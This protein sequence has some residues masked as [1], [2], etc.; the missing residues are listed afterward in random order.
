MLCKWDYMQSRQT[1]TTTLNILSPDEITI[2][3]DFG[4]NAYDIESDIDFSMHAR[5][6]SNPSIVSVYDTVSGEEY[7][8]TLNDPNTFVDRDETTVTY[9]RTTGNIMCIGAGPRSFCGENNLPAHGTTSNKVIILKVVIQPLVYVEGSR[10]E[11]YY[12][13][14][15][16]RGNYYNVWA[17]P[18]TCT[19]IAFSASG[20]Y[21]FFTSSMESY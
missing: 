2:L 15:T 9:D 20:R 17:R 4:F 10:G 6:S 12:N 5:Q 7:D 21:S 13:T 14:I 18:T 1:H 3:M 8:I 19:N 16:W 11:T